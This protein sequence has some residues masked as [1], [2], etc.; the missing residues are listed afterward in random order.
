MWMQK[1][2]QILADRAWSGTRLWNLLGHYVIKSK[3]RWPHLFALVKFCA[4][5]IIY[6]MRALGVQVAK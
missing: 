2:F 6:A 4:R 3:Y 1:R 5:K